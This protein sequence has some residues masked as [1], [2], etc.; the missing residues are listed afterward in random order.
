M[1]RRRYGCPHP[2][3]SQSGVREVEVVSGLC[4]CFLYLKQSFVRAFNDLQSLEKEVAQQ[5]DGRWVLKRNLGLSSWIENQS[6][7]SKSRSRLA[8]VS[9]VR[10]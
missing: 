3:S 10:A 1:E 8:I 4:C 6:C 5:P 7:D 2:E 9:S